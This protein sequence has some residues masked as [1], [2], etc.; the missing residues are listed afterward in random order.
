MEVGGGKDDGVQEVCGHRAGEL[1]VVI[2]KPPEDRSDPMQDLLV[3]V[4]LRPEGPQVVAALFLHL[5]RYW[6]RREA[7]KKKV[8]PE[9]Q[10]MSGTPILPV[11]V[12]VQS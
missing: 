5:G 8:M 7:A 4:E 1:N 10:A 6:K 12:R 9:P 11:P 3:V 2:P